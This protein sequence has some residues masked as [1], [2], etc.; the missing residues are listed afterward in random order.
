MMGDMQTPEYLPRLIQPRVATLFDVFPVVVVTGSRQTGK[1]T[2]VRRPELFPDHQYLS[3]DDV[4]LRDQARND[5]ELFLDRA[6]HLVIDEVQ[7]APDLLLA[8]KRRVDESRSR[9][10]YVLTGSSNLLVQ[11][12]VSESLAGRAGYVPLWP[13]T[14]R[15]QLGLGQA[16][17]WSELLDNRP[18]D[19]PAQRIGSRV[20]RQHTWNGTYG[21]SPPSI[22]SP[23]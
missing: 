20:T 10:R 12:D 5:P 21:S 14:L 18:D 2:L 7:H 4:L 23:I 16:G 15:E 9:G 8:I 1:S 6:D 11:R 3:L 22:A 19:W 13:F 17:I